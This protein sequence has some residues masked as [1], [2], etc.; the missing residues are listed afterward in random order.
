MIDL[1]AC[2]QFGSSSISS[3]GQQQ[4]GAEEGGVLVPSFLET[5]GVADVLEPP[6]VADKRPSAPPA[7][8]S[9]YDRRPAGWAREKTKEAYQH[10]L[11]A[12]KAYLLKQ[13]RLMLRAN[14]K[15]GGR[16][17]C[18]FQSRREACIC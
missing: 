9:S 10:M 8:P 4:H 2:W 14:K 3:S 18:S 5:R 6:P 12:Q 13:K 11:K 15:G 1:A 7:A 16:C 17:S